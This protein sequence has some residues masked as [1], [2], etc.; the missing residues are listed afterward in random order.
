MSKSQK[1][2]SS[3]IK[4]YSLEQGICLLIS[5]LQ[6]EPQNKEVREMLHEIA[7]NREHFGLTEQP[8]G[9]QAARNNDRKT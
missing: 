5:S 6:V 8:I 9:S 2:H 3:V 7:A 4:V 1:P